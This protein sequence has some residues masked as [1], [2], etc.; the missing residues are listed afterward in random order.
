MGSRS[1]RRR[2]NYSMLGALMIFSLAGFGA[3]SI[4]IS[5]VRLGISQC[6]DV[7]DAASQAAIVYYREA[8]SNGLTESQARLQ[9]QAAANYVVAK[10]GVVGSTATMTAL[11]WGN[12]DSSAAS[13]SEFTATSSGS[14]AN[15]AQVDLARSG[16]NSIAMTFGPL[17]GWN[18]LP[19]TG[20][21]TS[22]A[23]SLQVVLA[24]DITGSWDKDEFQYARQAAVAFYDILDDLHGPDD[25][26]GVEVWWSNYAYELVPMMRMT[27]LETRTN[28]GRDILNKLNVGNYSGNPQPGWE[29]PYSSSLHVACKV[30]GTSGN[31]TGTTASGIFGESS[32]YE[33]ALE[34]QWS[35]T[36]NLTTTPHTAGKG[37]HNFM[38]RYYQN[39]SGTDHHT[40]LMMARKMIKDQKYYS[41]ASSGYVT[42]TDP[43]AYR[44]VIVLTDGLPTAISTPFSGRAGI[45]GSGNSDTSSVPA[46]TSWSYTDANWPE[47]WQNTYGIPLREYRRDTSHTLSA[48]QSDTTALASNMFSVDR[49]N[50]WF[51]S[52]RDDN[53]FMETSS[54]GDGYYSYIP[55]GSV[56]ELVPTFQQ[57]ARSL[58]TSI[59]K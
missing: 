8:L 12:W 28:L 32:T 3:I 46:A 52:F 26:F 31:G 35:L 18:S 13:G 4:D 6:Q 56:S 44:A 55:T 58:P 24:L 38:P 47:T 49:T 59:V 33:S 2:G 41:P 16:S 40:G 19:V 39:E 30:Y 37:C 50:I 14:G 5:V 21:A 53:T 11:R 34:N 42:V 48:I 54:V 36:M 7:A 17:F 51:V 1:S 15:A 23:R 22:A 10:N 57:I 45:S 43:L 20:N 27:D 9:G 29:P 25:R